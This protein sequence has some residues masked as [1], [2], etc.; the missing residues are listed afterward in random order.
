[1]SKRALVTG[2]TS[3]IGAEF[4][5]VLAGEGM[6]LVLVG[7]NELRLAEMSKEISAMGVESETLV[8]DLSSEAGIAAIEERLTSEESPVDFLVNNAGFGMRGVFADVDIAEHEAVVNVNVMATTRLTHAAARAMRK[9]RRGD[10]LNISSVVAFTPA[11]RPSSTYAASKAYIAAFSEGLAPTLAKD[12]ITISA[13]CP[14]WVKTEF[15]SRAGINMSK[16]P[17]FMWL[18]PRQVVE[19]ALKDHRSGK[20]IS[21]PG[22]IYKVIMSGLRF[23][24]RGLQHSISRRVSRNQH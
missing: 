19:T 14:G 22:V 1:M 16:L 13:V 12:G 4:A 10:I 11:L 9:R 6:A 3:G 8:A 5:R 23:F 17:G 2:A 15:H 24:P 7:R 21:V 18:R 20:S